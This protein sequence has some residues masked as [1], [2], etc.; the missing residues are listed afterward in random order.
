M[1]DE[2]LSDR[3]K[4]NWQLVQDEVSQA[5]IDCGRDPG[6]IKIVGV[7]KYVDAR[8]TRKLVEV[9]C[10]SLAESRPQVLWDKSSQLSELPG[11]DWHL[12]GHLQRN[13]VRRTLSCTTPLL[14]QSADSARLINAVA[15]EASRQ[16]LTARILLEVNISG[17]DAKTGMNPDAAAAILAKPLESGVHVEGIMA[18]AGWGTDKDIARQQFD[19]VAHLARDFRNRFGVELPILS[20]GMSGDFPQAIAA[21]ATLVRI[22]SKLFD[23]II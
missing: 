15:E 5:A 11:I 8:V 6:S 22:G 7:S 17:D 13:K 14:I 10:R 19:Q 16:G 9:G 23:G 3:L 2:E 4:E 20:M 12:I 18:M 21:G 1:T